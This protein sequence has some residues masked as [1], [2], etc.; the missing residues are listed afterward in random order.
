MS[1]AFR[2]GSGDAALLWVL[3]GRLRFDLWNYRW[4]ELLPLEPL[5]NR[6][7]CSPQ[8]SLQFLINFCLRLFL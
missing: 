4:R 1:A 2:V 3:A 8:I 6:F 5:G 7:S